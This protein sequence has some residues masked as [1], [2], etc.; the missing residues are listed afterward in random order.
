MTVSA[1]LAELRLHIF[2]M[3]ENLFHY[4]KTVIDS[5][6]H[7]VL[8]MTKTNQISKSP[9]DLSRENIRAISLCVTNVDACAKYVSHYDVCNP[10]LPV[11]N[12]LSMRLTEV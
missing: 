7:S 4:R 10:K 12:V 11:R 3:R 2:A 1:R 9:P 5:F 6:S 8:N